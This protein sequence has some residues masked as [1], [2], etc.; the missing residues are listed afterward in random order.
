M[1]QSNFIRRYPGV[2]QLT[3]ATLVAY[4]PELGRWDGRDAD[5]AGGAGSVVARQ[6]EEAWQPVYSRRSWYG[7]TSAVYLR[8]GGAQD[9]WRS[10]RLLPASSGARQ[11]RQGSRDSGGSQASDATQRRG[12]SR[13]SLGETAPDQPSAF[14]GRSGLTF[15]TDTAYASTR[16][17]PVCGAQ[18]TPEA[19][20]SL[21]GVRPIL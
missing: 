4:L 6:R 16:N 9:R 1:R 15:N 2:G 21:P 20:R 7:A 11:T 13:H 17:G 8:M 14:S 3:A 18:R 10:T 19:G 12:P 5:I